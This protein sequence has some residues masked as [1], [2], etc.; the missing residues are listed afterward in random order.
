MI[1]RY[2]D[3]KYNIDRIEIKNDAFAVWG[4]VYAKDEKTGDYKN[5]DISAVT[6]PVTEHVMIRIERMNRE[7]LDEVLGTE[8]G[9]NPWGFL[10]TWSLPVR[11]DVIITFSA[12]E[13][14]STYKLS[15]ELQAAYQREVLRYY[16]TNKNMLQNFDFDTMKDE[17]LYAKQLEKSH[18]DDIHRRRK[19]EREYPYNMWREL[20]IPDAAQLKEQSQTRFTVEPKISIVVPAYRTPQKFLAE[21]IESV[22]SQTYSNWELCI[23]DASMDD[24]IVSVLEEY[25]QK[26]ARIVYSVLDDNYGISGNTNEALKIATGDYIGLLDHDDLLTPDALFEVVKCINETSADVVYTDEDKVTFELDYYFE[27]HFKPDFNLDYLRSCNYICH[28]FVVKNTVLEKVGL[29]DPECNGSQDYDFIL[30]CTHVAEKVEHVAKCLYNWRCH[31]NSTAMNPESKLY[32]YTSGKKALE[33]HFE[34]CQ[35]EGVRVEIAENYGFY[36][37]FYPMVGNPK[38]SVIVVNGTEFTCDYDN[39]ELIP[40][41]MGWAELEEKLP[42]YIENA[43]G[44]YVLI[45]FEDTSCE[46]KGGIELMI[47]NMQR[48]DVEAIGCK[49]LN[50]DG[51]IIE[52]GRIAAMDGD[53]RKMFAGLASEFHGYGGRALAQQ[54]LSTMGID[55]LMMKKDHATSI[56]NQDEYRKE[57]DKLVHCPYVQM[58]KMHK[59]EDK[60][61]HGEVKATEDPFYSSN[62]DTSRNLFQW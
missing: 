48:G 46:T 16:P 20:H 19:E 42:S 28:F 27:P 51:I 6:N 57:K 60:V 11:N 58:K 23:A 3:L 1:N 21:M 31:P 22:R 12:G 43:T 7:D 53:K 33:K 18:I 34:A 15:K 8:K 36:K 38:V 49:M 24:S 35:I 14:T 25:H 32:C 45:V 41:K 4:W 10:V 29:F 47:A 52:A 26:D 9:K 30:R 39:V 40:V 55:G 37:S 2:S 59:Y 54:E 17:L 44:E 62:F 61:F 50:A 13:K 56:Y 5:C